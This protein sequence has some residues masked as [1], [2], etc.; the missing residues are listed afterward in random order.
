VGF[1]VFKGKIFLSE[2]K[3][4]DSFGKI[5]LEPNNRNSKNRSSKTERPLNQTIEIQK[6]K[7]NQNH[8]NLD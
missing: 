6:K 7:K 8:F 3:V 2:I 5:F 4:G 1:F